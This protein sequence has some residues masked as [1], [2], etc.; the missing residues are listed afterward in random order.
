MAREKRMRGLWI[1]LLA[2]L[3][4]A[5]GGCGQS[6]LS[7]K[8]LNQTERDRL[9]Q[10]LSRHKE[11][12]AERG[13]QL[14]S[15]YS[16]NERMVIEVRKSKAPWEALSAEETERLKQ[17]LYETAGYTFELQIDSFVLP[18]QADITGTITA[19]DGNRVLVVGDAQKGS[20]PSAT[21]VRFQPGLTEELKIGYKINAWSDGMINE[22]Y[23]S[24]TSGLQLQVVDF[25]VG[26][27]QTEGVI[28]ELSLDDSEIDQRFIEVDHLK[29]RVLPFTQYRVN[30]DAGTQ[31]SLSIGDKVQVWT[32]GYE[33]MPDER[34]ASQINEITSE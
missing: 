9:S 3:M 2:T 34:F 16:T 20:N 14:H 1:A 6:G 21:W 18:K 5:A 22:S 33:I 28:T 24:Q 30:G 7:H 27:G 4:I 23:P 31:G 26:K 8:N 10:E 32:L 25:E 15:S 19:L 12:F 29:Y 11:I 17:D 13:V